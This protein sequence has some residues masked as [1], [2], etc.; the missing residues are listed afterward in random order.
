MNDHPKRFGIIHDGL[1]N[2]GTAKRMQI[3]TAMKC[4]CRS[5]SSIGR[6]RFPGET[7]LKLVMEL[8]RKLVSDSQI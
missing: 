8:K 6:P 7:P 3:M 4:H 2:L 1:D 5:I